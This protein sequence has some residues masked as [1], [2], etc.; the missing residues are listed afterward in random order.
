MQSA[1]SRA[2]WSASAVTRPISTHSAPSL[3]LM[4]CRLRSRLTIATHRL[5]PTLGAMTSRVIWLSATCECTTLSYIFYG[6]SIAGVSCRRR[7]PLPTTLALTRD[8]AIEL[9]A[10]ML[11]WASFW[12]QLDRNFHTDLATLL[13]LE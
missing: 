5:R 6:V 7:W 1:T 10:V 8:N 9:V 13:Q 11:N 12:G 2:C 3:A 4:R